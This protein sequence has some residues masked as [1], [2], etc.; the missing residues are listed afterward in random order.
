MFRT[1]KYI[2][3]SFSLCAIMA[4]T[5]NTQVYTF[6]YGIK[7]FPAGGSLITTAVLTISDKK[8][9]REEVLSEHQFLL[10]MSGAIHSKANPAPVDLFF[11]NGI[12]SCSREKDTIRY[13]H[14]VLNDSAWIMNKTPSKYKTDYIVQDL[15]VVCPLLKE[16]WRVR[17]KYDIRL[18][19]YNYT[20]YPKATGWSNDKFWP[21]LAQVNYL[22]ATYNS[23]GINSYI[24]G[25]KLF[26]FLK[27][28]QDSSWVA[29]YK[30][31]K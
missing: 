12:Y 4:F 10:E 7:L 11:K 23:D 14:K 9:V 1:D 5:L 29:N 25:E 13:K 15:K 27:D 8:I 6:E 19:N 31:L 30:S 28:V 24:Y 16:L 17:Y 2:L 20:Q 26:K 21:T 18:K 3:L 22:K